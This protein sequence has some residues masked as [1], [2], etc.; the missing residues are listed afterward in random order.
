MSAALSALLT[1]P[2]FAMDDEMKARV[3]AVQGVKLNAQQDDF[4]RKLK[5]TVW[6]D[7]KVSFEEILDGLSM[8]SRNADEGEFQSFFPCCGKEGVV[9]ALQKIRQALDETLPSYKTDYLR[10]KEEIKSSVVVEVYLDVLSRDLRGILA[11]ALIETEDFLGNT[12]LVLCTNLHHKLLGTQELLSKK[13]KSFYFSDH[14][15]T[16][17]AYFFGENPPQS[18][19]VADEI[20]RV[21]KL[22][23]KEQ[24]AMEEQVREAR[25]RKMQLDAF[26]QSEQGTLYGVTK[27]LIKERLRKGK[28]GDEFI[29]TLANEE[30]FNYLKVILNEDSF[31]NRLANLNGI[32]ASKISR[33]RTQ[34]EDIALIDF[35]NSVK[36]WRNQIFPDKGDEGSFL[37]GLETINRHCGKSTRIDDSPNKAF[38]QILR[39]LKEI[40]DK[41]PQ[42]E[43][44]KT[45]VF[46]SF[47]FIQDQHN[48]CASGLMGRSLL[49]A[50]LISNLLVDAV[51]KPFVK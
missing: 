13:L 51:E 21:R 47:G 43:R 46:Q 41:F 40:S 19:E 29:M 11:P 16:L 9:T 4:I 14:T 26:L 18:Q 38:F 37:G 48:M 34:L 50:S 7:I 36:T 20:E 44:V 22:Q 25:L 1:S 12:T 32:N 2:G 30:C 24:V 8:G 15:D 39:L 42:D 33:G 6:V 28:Q 23:I 3:A 45:L 17:K 49:L 35:S 5:N 10:H 27:A 31:L